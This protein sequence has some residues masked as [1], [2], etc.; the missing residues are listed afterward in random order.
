MGVAYASM[1]FVRLI[2]SYATLQ[3]A[4]LDVDLAVPNSPQA[5]IALCFLMVVLTLWL[6]R[7]K[8]RLVVAFCLY[9]TLLSFFGYWA[10]STKAIKAHTGLATI[11]GSDPV[12]NFW[13]GATWLD[14]IVFVGTV[15]MAII[16]GR[17]LWLAH[18]SEHR[19][20]ITVGGGFA[21]GH[22]RT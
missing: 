7:G 14:P 3:A 12:S 2:R 6:L 18:R 13:F 17:L 11:P 8:G 20:G 19:D 5:M 16:A 1:F 21:N 15:A 9:L 4:G 10:Y 22:T